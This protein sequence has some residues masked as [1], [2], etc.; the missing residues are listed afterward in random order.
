MQD[1]ASAGRHGAQHFAWHTFQAG[2]ALKAVRLGGRFTCP[3]RLAI[4]PP[5]TMF[6]MMSRGLAADSEG[7]SCKRAQNFARAN[8]ARQTL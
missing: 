3:V 7:G 5:S 1:T 2:H 6:L 8:F 4:Q